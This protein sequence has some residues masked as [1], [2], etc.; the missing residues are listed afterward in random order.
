MTKTQE[1]MTMHGNTVKLGYEE[2]FEAG[3]KRYHTAVQNRQ[4]DEQELRM[5]ENLLGH[6]DRNNEQDSIKINIVKSAI[7]RMQH[8]IKVLETETAKIDKELKGM[9]E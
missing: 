6:Y 9:Y 1:R 8:Q 7:R 5:W 2:K 3:V 4:A